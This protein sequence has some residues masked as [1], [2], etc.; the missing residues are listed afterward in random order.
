MDDKRN[1]QSSFE[2]PRKTQKQL[3]VEIT[4]ISGEY[5]AENIHRIIPSASYAKKVVTEL[6]GDKSIKLVSKNGLRGYRL[7]IKAK[8]QLLAENPTRYKE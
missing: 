7:E 5:P 1:S 2:Q 6:I 3:L 8:R 4:A